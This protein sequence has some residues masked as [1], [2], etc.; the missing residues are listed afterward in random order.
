MTNL[1]LSLSL[2]LPPNTHRFVYRYRP[3]SCFSVTSVFNWPRFPTSMKKNSDRLFPSLGLLLHRNF[4]GNGSSVAVQDRI[5]NDFRNRR[6]ESREHE[7]GGV[8]RALTIVRGR[9]RASY[10]RR[11]V[12]SV[13][14]SVRWSGGLRN[15][16]DETF[17]SR[18]RS[19]RSECRPLRDNLDRFAPSE[20]VFFTLLP[21]CPLSLLPLLP[22]RPPHPSSLKLKLPLGY[23]KGICM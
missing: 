21:H 17:R 20:S 23:M 9:Y 7:L 1:F 3:S 22:P 12:Y 2:S 16:D 10:S 14:Y 18:F 15:V 5:G 13:S 11:A 19:S 8:H 4:P 6:V